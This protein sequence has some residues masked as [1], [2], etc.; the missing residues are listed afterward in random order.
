MRRVVDHIILLSGVSVF[1]LPVLVLAVAATHEGGLGERDSLRLLPGSGF[2]E[3]LERL[4][5]VGER[6]ADMPT[7]WRM[8]GTSAVIGAGIAGVTTAVSFLAAYTMVFMADRGAR[9]FF[10]V[11]LATLYFPVEARMLPTFVVAAELGL[12]GS[13]AGMILPVLPL[14]LGTLIFRQHLKT[15]PPSLLEA[16]RLDGAG[17]LRFLRD[18]AMPLSWAPIGAVLLITFIFGWNQYLWPL[19][20]SIDGSVWTLMRG[21]GFLG[22]GSGP[23]LALALLSMGPPLLLALLFSRFLSRLGQIRV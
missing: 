3:N 18:F 12:L 4:S 2:T 16:A 6:A 7:A 15:M 23:G 20:I 9:L 11:T 17:P 21:L 14:A 1:C 22:G 19:M 13:V 5:T 10:W 8:M